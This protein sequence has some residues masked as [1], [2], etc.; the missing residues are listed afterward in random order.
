MRGNQ[1]ERQVATW[2]ISRLKASPAAFIGLIEAPDEASAI[3]AAIKQFAVRPHD[4]K[5]LIAVRH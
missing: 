5:R 1:R 2:E 4:Q 3:K